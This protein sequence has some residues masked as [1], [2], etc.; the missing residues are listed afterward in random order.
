VPSNEWSLSTAWGPFGLFKDNEPIGCDGGCGAIIDTGT[1][2]LTPPTE[3]TNAI[4]E[5]LQNGNIQDCSD[6]SKFPTLHFKLDGKDFSLPPQSYI[7]DAGMQRGVAE[8]YQKPEGLALPLLPM[9]KAAADKANLARQRGEQVP[10]HQCA[11][12]LG[13]GLEDQGTTQYGPML[14]I[15]MPLFRKYAV[16]FD[17]SKDF[18]GE[19]ARTMHFAEASSDCEGSLKGNRFKQ[20][21]LQKVNLDKL[22]TSRLAT[23]F[24]ALREKMKGKDMKLNKFII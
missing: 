9:D 16:Q 10:V 4:R 21:G 7:A 2:L 1:S 24:K 14:I 17:L 15:G 13:E 22:R 19:E 3:V 23:G 8:I 20:Q 12:L 5:Q 6:L 11:L 18:E